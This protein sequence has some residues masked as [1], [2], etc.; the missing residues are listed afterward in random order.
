MLHSTEYISLD[1]DYY[2]Q[3]KLVEVR[4]TNLYHISL[5]QKE[6]KPKFSLRDK[7]LPIKYIT[8]DCS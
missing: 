3:W 6:E 5:H 4:H 8:L 1:K 2:H 7:P